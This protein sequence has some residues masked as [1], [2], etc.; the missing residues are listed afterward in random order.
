MLLEVIQD[1]L[2]PGLRFF[3]FFHHLTGCTD[4]DVRRAP[5]GPPAQEAALGLNRPEGSEPAVEPCSV[6]AFGPKAGCF[7]RKERFT[8]SVG[9]GGQEGLAGASAVGV[10]GP[11][12]QDILHVR[13]GQGLEEIK[14]ESEMLPP[15]FKALVK[16][17]RLQPGVVRDEDREDSHF[18]PGAAGLNLFE[19]TEDSPGAHL[20]FGGHQALGIIPAERGPVPKQPVPD[21]PALVEGALW[22]VD[23][24]LEIREEAQGKRRSLPPGRCR[25]HSWVLVS[26][27]RF[28]MPLH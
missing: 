6:R 27:S 26:R 13:R 28:L 8:P 23:R 25:R 1:V 18:L 16:P 20:Q 2:L 5:G 9:Q 11:N 15:D 19:G 14:K 7:S 10:G 17:A 12:A 22:D 4:V 3:D 24:R 21:K